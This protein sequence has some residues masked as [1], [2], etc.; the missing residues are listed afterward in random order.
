MR[1]QSALDREPASTATSEVTEQ[2]AA[3]TVED[4]GKLVETTLEELEGFH[5][6]KSIVRSVV[7]SGRVVMR[8]TQTYCGVL[9]D[10]N[11]RKPICRLFFNQGRKCIGLFDAEKNCTRH[12]LDS[13][14][15]IYKFAEQFVQYG[16]TVRPAA[17]AGLERRSDDARS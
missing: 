4:K 8:D 5:I 6:V 12:P 10:D 9:L 13:L 3:G 11:N 15:D 2:A 7:A 1:L 17:T 16:P 14:D